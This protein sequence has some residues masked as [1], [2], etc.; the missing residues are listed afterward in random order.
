MPPPL[1]LGTA[2]VRLIPAGTSFPSRAG[3]ACPGTNAISSW[4][5]LLLFLTRQKRPCACT[6]RIGRRTAHLNSLA[7]RLFAWIAA[8]ET[9]VEVV[10][11]RARE[12]TDDRGG[13]ARTRA[14]LDQA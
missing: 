2:S 1:L 8:R 5:I 14:G 10:R 13:R 7:G 12:S 11:A 3:A 6:T 9:P 4:R